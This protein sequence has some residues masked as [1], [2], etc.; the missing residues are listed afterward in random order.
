MLCGENGACDDGICICEP[1]YEGTGCEDI[2]RTKFLG[3]WTSSEFVCG[4][5]YP[6]EYKFTITEGAEVNKI[7]IV[8][9]IFLFTLTADVTGNS[10]VIPVQYTQINGDS[11]E[12]SGSGVMNAGVFTLTLMTVNDIDCTGVLVK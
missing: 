6:N 7:V 3:I 2:S 5:E 10:F 1:G 4:N 8:N 9:G 12:W 11:Y